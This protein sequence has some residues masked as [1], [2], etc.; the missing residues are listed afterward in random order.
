MSEYL[1]PAVA[2]AL[3]ALDERTQSTL[4]IAQQMMAADEGNFYPVDM[5]AI[6]AIKRCLS[7]SAG[8]KVLVE[9]KNLVCARALLRLQIDTA[10][11]FFALFLA[12]RPHDFANR[13]LSGEQINRMKDRNGKKMTDAYLVARLSANHPWLP[14]VYK[15]TSG[16]IHLS[17]R[18]LFSPVQE[19][20]RESRSVQFVIAETDT[21]Y[22]EFSWVEAVKCFNEATDIF[23]KYLEGW[24]FSKA[25][26]DLVAKLRASTQER[27]DGQ[28]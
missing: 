9:A 28:Q 15:I 7:L 27:D 5:L 2:N 4:R 1:T 23:L 13:V 6:G 17:D 18:H 19:V 11:R 25:N 12:E 21:H 10:I 22:P 20:D 24:A 3:R 8:F 16:Y 14:K 26:P